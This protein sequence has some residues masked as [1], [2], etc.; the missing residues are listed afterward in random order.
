[1]FQVS[2]HA[3]F[4]PSR[5]ES[6]R[7]SLRAPPPGAETQPATKGKRDRKLR[8][9]VFEVPANTGKAKAIFD[10]WE[11]WR[12]GLRAEAITARRDPM[13]GRGLRTIILAEEEA[14]DP[15]ISASKNRIG[16]AAQQMIR[17]QATATVAT[18]RSSR[19]NDVRDAI[20]D[21]F[22]P[23]RWGGAARRRFEALPIDRR[24]AIETDLAQ[25]RHELHAINTQQA[26]MVQAET[27]VMHKLDG[28]L[29]PVSDRAR[30]L[31]RTIFLGV[32][33]RHRWPRFQRLAMR[34]DDRAGFSQDGSKVWLEPAHHGGLFAWWLHLKP[35]GAKE[36]LLLPIR[37]WGRERADGRG[38]G[39]ARPG[40][41]GKTV[42]L[43]LGDDGKL[44]V[45]LT[46]DLT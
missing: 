21:Q 35:T 15:W 19:Q 28:A 3:S 27:A 42:N 9:D 4:S 11:L 17:A 7:G 8:A 29:V 25:L 37:G 45:A 31:A 6:D 24:E 18:W 33:A 46:R 32:A 1:M 16:A 39:L 2:A 43:F 30:R 10:L 44:Q 13:A 12:R 41:L 34:L 14:Q 40:T 23:R 22:T 5:R 20:T 36:P 38:T 26:W